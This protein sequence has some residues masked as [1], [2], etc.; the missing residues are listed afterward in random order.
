MWHLQEHAVVVLL[1]ASICSC[2]LIVDQS[3]TNPNTGNSIS[4]SRIQVQASYFFCT[5]YSD[6]VNTGLSRALD[7]DQ[8]A[9]DALEA[10]GAG[11]GSQPADVAKSDLLDYIFVSTRPGAGQPVDPN[12]PNFSR[13]KRTFEAVKN[14]NTPTSDPNRL[15]LDVKIYCDFSRF[16]ENESCKTDDEGKRIPKPGYACD[17]DIK[18]DVPMGDEYTECKKVFDIN[19]PSTFEIG[20]D[21][22][23]LRYPSKFAQMQLCVG[24]LKDRKNSPYHT[25]TEIERDGLLDKMDTG[26]LFDHTVLHE[27]THA[28]SGS[29]TNDGPRG[30]DGKGNGYRWEGV[31]SKSGITAEG[32]EGYTNADSYAFFGLGMLFSRDIA[33]FH[34]F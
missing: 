13:V 5:G 29:P 9:L 10:L 26:A 8:A 31:T 14:L 34:L 30:P 6:L 20:V 3:C 27:L 24:F 2:K 25:W 12:N 11:V 23:T 33:L 21:A 7:L 1:A 18:I 22:Y 15:D 19:D 4:A 16:H 32:N 17:D 28:I